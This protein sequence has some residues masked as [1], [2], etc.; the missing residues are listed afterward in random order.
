[1]YVSHNNFGG[2]DRIWTLTFGNDMCDVRAV[3]VNYLR[4]D[5]MY[6]DYTAMWW[7]YHEGIFQLVARLYVCSPRRYRKVTKEIWGILRQKFSVIS[8]QFAETHIDYIF[9]KSFVVYV[10]FWAL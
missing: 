6:V 7:R 1:M 4:A 2:F 8:I 9:K 3:R 10:W 5:V